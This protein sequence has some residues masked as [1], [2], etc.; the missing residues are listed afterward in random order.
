MIDPVSTIKKRNIWMKTVLKQ[1]SVFLYYV[2][3]I[4]LKVFYYFYCIMIASMRF[5]SPIIIYS[6][7][8]QKIRDNFRIYKGRLKKSDF[9]HFWV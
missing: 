3:D 9:Y 8:L 5:N 7:T 4:F 1:N 6:S 2:L